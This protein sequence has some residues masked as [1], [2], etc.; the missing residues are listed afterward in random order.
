[1]VDSIAVF[2]ALSCCLV[3]VSSQK[4]IYTPAAH[5]KTE[6]Q[7]LIEIADMSDLIAAV[8]RFVL[9]FGTGKKHIFWFLCRTRPLLPNLR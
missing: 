6:L 2:S 9:F 7:A 3:K 5:L 4:S 1:M 8:H